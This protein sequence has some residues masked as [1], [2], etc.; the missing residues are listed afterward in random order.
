MR[1][2]L[3]ETL[4]LPLL[5]SAILCLTAGCNNI[6]EWTVDD[7]SYPALMAEGRRAI[8]ERNYDLAR[9]KFAQAME[10]EPQ[11][12]EARYH[13]AKASVLAEDVDVF[14]LVQ[15]LTEDD[16]DGPGGA[17]EIFESEIPTANA[18]YRVNAV[19]LDALEP[20]RHGQ[21]FGDFADA[22]VDLDLAIA[23]TLRGIFRLR[24][25]NG[26]GVIDGDDLTT[27]DFG[28]G[29]DG[30]FSLDG[31][32]NLPPEDLNDMIDDVN[33]LLGEG[34]DLL[35]DVLDGT[36]IDVDEL[37]DLIDSLGGDLSAFYVNTGLPGN[38]GI[39]DNDGDGRVDEECLNGIDDDLDG[40]T[41][42]DSRLAGC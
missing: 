31:I 15:T 41:D 6:F 16:G 19:V 18:I 36:G 24:D 10:L 21:T 8:Q 37:N 29:D 38:P 39:G 35:G 26:D 3:R 20:I 17:T 4:A 12:A 14:E 13:F 2:Q 34:G 22:D 30:D 25:T 7:G 11:S 27:D 5:L 23:Y 9:E 1:R 40:L 32:E 28:L 42:E 33:D